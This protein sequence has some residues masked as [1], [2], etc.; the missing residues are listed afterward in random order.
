[1]TG[2]LAP[3]ADPDPDTDTDLATDPRVHAPHRLGDLVVAPVGWGTLPLTGGYGAAPG[4]R[5][6]E[7]VGRLLDV[8]LAGGQAPPLV[9]T[10][11]FYGAGA[12][13]EQ[14][15]R[16]LGHRRD[17]VV[18]AGRGG[19]VVDGPGRPR[20][21]DGSPAHLRRACEASLRRL[22]T[23]HLDLYSL[24]RVDPRVPLEESVGA[25]HDLVRAG[26]VR[27]V[28][29][30]EVTGEEL[31][32]ACA[33]GPVAAVASEWSLVSR[34]VEADVVPVAR[35]LGVVIVACSP[36]ARGLLGGG[37]PEPGEGDYR[38]NHPR[39]APGNLPGNNR[40]ARRAAAL[41]AAAGWDPAA[42]ALAWVLGA[43]D[44]ARDV[45]A[46]VGTVRPAHLR[47][48]CAAA[49]R[50]LPPA[51]RAGLEACFPVGGV[52]GDRRPRVPGT[53]ADPTT[54]PASVET[55]SSA[56]RDARP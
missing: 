51:V 14:L 44:G 40:L 12:V 43:G 47:T 36:L 34:D 18:L 9:D 49:H 17:D 28:G 54:A 32:R 23:D 33:V 15:G 41:A 22:R 2:P 26:L 56:E 48:A 25:L 46:L 45:V 20:R 8:V 38:R 30:S 19:A 42:A 50:D 31:R 53:A 3:P 11:D 35:A 13:E 5:T 21:I 29:L 6:D 39:F 7:L 37:V 52:A 24:A 1:M 16:T 4:G 10:A 55:A 27:H